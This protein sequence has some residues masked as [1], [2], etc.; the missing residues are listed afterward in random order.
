MQ[1][2]TLHSM[3]NCIADSLMKEVGTDLNGVEKRLQALESHIIVENGGLTDSMRQVQ[4]E[5]AA[6]SQ[7]LEVCKMLVYSFLW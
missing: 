3:L 7:K 2:Y 1:W 4:E 5:M 6:L